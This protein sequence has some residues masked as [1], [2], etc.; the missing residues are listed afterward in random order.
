MG[1]TAI[2]YKIF[3]Y[4]QETHAHHLD[5]IRGLYCPESDI[6]SSLALWIPPILAYNRG[7]FNSETGSKTH[8]KESAPF[9]LIS[10]LFFPFS[11]SQAT[12]FFLLHPRRTK[13]P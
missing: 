7:I 3:T 8:G 10:A 4:E 13:L 11:A 1:E 9:L 12:S 6:I 2:S 5:R